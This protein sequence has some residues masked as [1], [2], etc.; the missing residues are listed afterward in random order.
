MGRHATADIGGASA[1][2]RWVL[3]PQQFFQVGDVVV[4]AKRRQAGQ[5]VGLVA[6]AVGAQELQP[7]V[8]ARLEVHHMAEYLERVKVL[9]AAAQG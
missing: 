4:L 7:W 9:V 8:F 2:P 1:P 3:P 5:G 6:R